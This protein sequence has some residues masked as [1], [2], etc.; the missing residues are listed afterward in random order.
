[1]PSCVIPRR[2]AWQNSSVMVWKTENIPN[3]LEALDKKGSGQNID[4]VIYL[5]PAG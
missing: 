3:E 5:L 4:C 2:S 1:M